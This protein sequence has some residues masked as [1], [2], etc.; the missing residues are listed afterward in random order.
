[1]I[2]VSDTSPIS[3]LLT[4]NLEHLLK[5]MF[6]EVVIPPCVHDEL[7]RHHPRLPNFLRV[8]RVKDASAVERLLT[9]L[10]IGEAEAVILAEEN[11]ADALLMDENDGRKIAERRGL[12]VI[13]LLGVLVKAKMEGR[14]VALSPIM[15]RLVTDAHF[16]I[17]ED[18]RREILHGVQEF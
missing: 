3:N 15:D 9:Q 7:I 2:V 4:L 16:W 11:K 10:D 5:D 13:G 17:S 12:R 1:M 14:I 18:L 6:H 8:T